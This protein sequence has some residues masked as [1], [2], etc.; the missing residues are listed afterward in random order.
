[1]SVA[2]HGLLA[3]EG[4]EEEAREDGRGEVA[5]RAEGEAGQGGGEVAAVAEEEAQEVLV[6]ERGAA[7]AP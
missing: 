5:R 6:V 7:R 2:L 4:L 3:H 1:V